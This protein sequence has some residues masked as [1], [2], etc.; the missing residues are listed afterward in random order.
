M[1][2]KRSCHV[3][4]KKLSIAN[5]KL[6]DSVW[7]HSRSK[8]FFQS[9][10]ITN[11]NDSSLEKLPN[12]NQK[13]QKINL[14]AA[15]MPTK[16]YSTKECHIV[17][18]K[19]PIT[20]LKTAR[21]TLEKCPVKNLK[22]PIIKLKKITLPKEKQEGNK[23]VKQ[24]KKASNMKKRHRRIIPKKLIKIRNDRGCKKPFRVWKSSN[25]PKIEKEKRKPIIPNH[26]ENNNDSDKEN[27]KILESGFPPLES[28]GGTGRWSKFALSNLV[29]SRCNIL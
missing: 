4:L 23:I 27:G 3:V 15:P 9:S 29:P 16:D 22:I 14:D 18:E 8:I 10:N 1:S 2:T 17:L 13:S 11:E 20:N 25:Q 7:S 19:C 24:T 26:E 5:L 12:D 21:I 6:P 28:L